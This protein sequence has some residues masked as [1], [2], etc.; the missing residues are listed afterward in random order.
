M[1]CR[2]CQQSLSSYLDNVLS[3]PE[4]QEIQGH[5]AHCSTCTE[6]L[7]QFQENRQLVQHLPE[8]DVTD[9]MEMR[10]WLRLQDPRRNTS[11]D[12]I[13]AKSTRWMREGASWTRGTNS[14]KWTGWSVGT[15]ATCAASFVFYFT[16]LQSPPE[17]SA[18]EVVVSMDELLDVLDPAD[19][20]SIL[21]EEVPEETL[22]GWLEEDSWLLEE[23]DGQTGHMGIED[24]WR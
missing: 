14:A 24:L 19:G 11:T 18:E 21:S 15:L 12:S 2:R 16:T 1:T 10:L 17:V 22:P 9:T 5:L 13:W 7:R 3:A 6:R 4:R 8:Q 20:N 23:G